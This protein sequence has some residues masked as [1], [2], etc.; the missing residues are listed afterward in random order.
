MSSLTCPH[1][2]AEIEIEARAVQ[3]ELLLGPIDT[4]PKKL[5]EKFGGSLK[6]TA[7]PDSLKKSDSSNESAESNRIEQF[8]EDLIESVR[9]IVGEMEFHLN[10]QLWRSYFATSP[11]ALRYAVSKWNGL[12]PIQQRSI[13]HPPAWLTHRY[14]CAR[15]EIARSQKKVSH[16]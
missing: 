4:T 11:D 8:E 3:A 6:S 12:T 7:G 2:G 14:K 9:A 13:K 5:D 15:D 16:A 1:C 10:A